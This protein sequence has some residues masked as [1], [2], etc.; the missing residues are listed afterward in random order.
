VCVGLIVVTRVS[1]VCDCKPCCAPACRKAHT[2]EYVPM[3]CYFKIIIQPFRR[4]KGASSL[5]IDD[6]DQA[7]DESGMRAMESVEVVVN[8]GGFVNSGW[9][10]MYVTKNNACNYCVN[11]A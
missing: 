1:Q 8:H 7:R 6:D 5:T 2:K 4:P 9:M 3:F 11:P 10:S